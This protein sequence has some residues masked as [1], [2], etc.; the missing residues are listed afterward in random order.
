MFWSKLTATTSNLIGARLL[1]STKYQEVGSC[2]YYPER[3]TITLS[4]SSIMPKSAIAFAYIATVNVLQFI[5]IISLFFILVLFDLLVTLAN[6]EASENF[7]AYKFS[8]A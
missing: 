1:N 3:Q 6:K 7:R 2:L 4:P 8:G 5:E